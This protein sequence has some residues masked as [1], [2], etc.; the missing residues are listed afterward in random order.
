MTTATKKLLQTL[1]ICG[2]ALSVI[3]ALLVFSGAIAKQTYLY[4]MLLGMLLWF[5]TAVFWIK[6][7]HLG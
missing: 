3:P 2:L 7:D 5:S 4:L 6:K 1:S